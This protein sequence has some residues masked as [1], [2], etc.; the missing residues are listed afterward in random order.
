MITS[1]GSWDVVSEANDQL[2]TYVTEYAA[3]LPPEMTEGAE[4]TPVTTEPNQDNASQ[5]TPVNTD[6]EN[7]FKKFEF[8]TNIFK[9]TSK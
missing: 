9:T 8:D 7:I 6:A 5:E 1:I 2:Q 3:E 4:E